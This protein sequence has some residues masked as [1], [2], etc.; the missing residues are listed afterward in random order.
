VRPCRGICPTR[1]SQRPVSARRHAGF[2]P[3]KRSEEG[4][5]A[6][7]RE[8]SLSPARPAPLLTSPL[9]TSPI[10][11][12]TRPLQ[13]AFCD[14]LGRPSYKKRR[15]SHPETEEPDFRPCWPRPDK[16]HLERA[17]TA[18]DAHQAHP[19]CAR[20][21]SISP[22]HLTAPRP[23]QT[24]ARKGAFRSGAGI[25]SDEGHVGDKGTSSMQFSANRPLSPR[26]SNGVLLGA[27]CYDPDG[28]VG[29]RASGRYACLPA[30]L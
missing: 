21:R 10:T 17:M 14:G 9:L 5:R 3:Q 23:V 15:V 1:E 30:G 28:Y 24:A 16:M 4:C 27:V 11:P 26:P 6:S 25:P 29:G 20:Q 13:S 19:A 8:A 22:P 18:T 12:I 7:W 2:L